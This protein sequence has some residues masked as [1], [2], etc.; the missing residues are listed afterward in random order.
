VRVTVATL[1]DA[2]ELWPV[3]DAVFGDHPSFEAWRAE[4]WDRHAAREGF[5]LARA[6]VAGELVGFAY[7]YTGRTGQWWTDH[8][9]ELLAP[10]VAEAWL[11]GHFELV[12]IGVLPEAR[13]RGVGRELLTS[14]CDGLPHERWLLMTTADESDPARRLYA[15]HGWSVLGPGIGEGTVVMGRLRVADGS[16]ARS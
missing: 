2:V 13:G 8:V 5:R 15:R 3:H 1:A 4:V 10:G 14:L 7:G 16:G 9:A 11:G 6:R 12:S